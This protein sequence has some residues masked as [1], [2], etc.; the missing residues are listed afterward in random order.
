M[1]AFRQKLNAYE[2][3]EYLHLVKKI[4]GGWKVFKAFSVFHQKLQEFK[5]HGW[6]F[7]LNFDSSFQ[8][9]SKGILWKS[10]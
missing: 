10:T 3:H 8:I 1:N 2:T 6:N 5:K 4:K 9:I 7:F